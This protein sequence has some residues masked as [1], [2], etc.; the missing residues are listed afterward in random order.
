MLERLRGTLWRNADFVRL[1]SAQTVRQ[2]GS[3]VTLLALPFVAIFALRATTFEIAA[4]GV[5]DTRR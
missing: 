2:V 4:P 5:V 1:W 3:R